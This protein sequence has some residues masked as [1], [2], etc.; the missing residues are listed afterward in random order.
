MITVGNPLRTLIGPQDE[1]QPNPGGLVTT[2]VVLG[3]LGVGG[4]ALYRHYSGDNASAAA[5]GSTGVGTQEGGLV[6]PAATMPADKHTQTGVYKNYSWMMRY[7]PSYVAGPVWEWSAQ[8][9]SGSFSI[10]HMA[11]DYAQARVE[12]LSFIDDNAG[13]S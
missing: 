12:M 7:Q 9:L 1:R 10:K 11:N 5:G 6:S 4:Y 8:D 2:V 13:A 3:I